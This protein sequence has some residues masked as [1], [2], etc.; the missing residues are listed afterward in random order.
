[1][2]L[3]SLAQLLMLMG[4]FRMRQRAMASPQALRG[5]MPTTFMTF[6]NKRKV[7]LAGNGTPMQGK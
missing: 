3:M 2:I 4:V 7:L 1:M 6:H 5:M